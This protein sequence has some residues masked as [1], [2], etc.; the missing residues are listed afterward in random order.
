MKNFTEHPPVQ[1]DQK[2]R[3][4]EK[5]A[6]YAEIWERLNACMGHLT[7]DDPSPLQPAPHHSSEAT[8]GC[9]RVACGTC[10]LQERRRKLN[11]NKQR[12]WQKVQ[13]AMSMLAQKITHC[14]AWDSPGVGCHLLHLALTANLDAQGP[15]QSRTSLLS[16]S[17]LQCFPTPCSLLVNQS[18][19]HTILL[20]P[21]HLCSCCAYNHLFQT[22]LTPCFSKLLLHWCLC[23]RSVTMRLS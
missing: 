16:S 3:H 6:W 19:L 18:L 15:L 1:S 7:C 10:G 2:H 17:V 13:K 4:S 21:P 20:L 8:S 5:E 14:P 22:L 11:S 12:P 23:L 9:V